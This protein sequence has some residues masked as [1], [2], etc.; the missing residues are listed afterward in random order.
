[1]PLTDGHPPFGNRNIRDGS[2]NL[3]SL[4]WNSGQPD[5][6]VSVYSVV[7]AAHSLGSWKDSTE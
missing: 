3:M 5:S 4:S 6:P 2:L 7:M 1:M